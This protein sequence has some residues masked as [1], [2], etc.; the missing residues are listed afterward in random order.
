MS[1]KTNQLKQKEGESAAVRIRVQQNADLSR[2]FMNY[3][4]SYQHMQ[5][6]YQNNY[7]LRLK[8]TL[9]IVNADVTEEQMEELISK[10]G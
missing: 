2:K 5:E 3:M 9:K 8:R 7:K 10:Q 1:E 4:K 6:E